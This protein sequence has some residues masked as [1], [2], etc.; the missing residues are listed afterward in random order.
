MPFSVVPN[1]SDIEV[2]L[3]LR[4]GTKTYTTTQAIK[5]ISNDLMAGIY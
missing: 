1:Q 5:Y 3:D 2:L 4:T